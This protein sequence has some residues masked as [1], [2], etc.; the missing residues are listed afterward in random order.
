M[1]AYVEAELTAY[2]K[3]HTELG[4]LIAH[5]KYRVDTF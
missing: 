4:R 3:I 1:Q 5:E 2:G